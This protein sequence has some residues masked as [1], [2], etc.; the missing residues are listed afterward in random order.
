MPS[1]L[2]TTIG[3][4]SATSYV[5]LAEFL[6]YLDDRP[7]ATAAIDEDD[8]DQTRALLRAAKRLNQINWLGN[9]V[10]TKQAL[11]WPRV[12]AAKRDG[13]NVYTQTWGWYSGYGDQYRTDEIPPAVKEA[14]MEF[15]FSILNGFNDGDEAEVKSFSDD[16]MSVTFDQPRQAGDLPAS[17]A[18]LLEGLIARGRR[19]RG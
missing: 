11:A 12:G 19:E 4:A 7:G 2:V 18:R 14:Q 5:T 8:E 9:R 10:D 15:A 16:K 13:A 6:T 3:S 17:V 1:A